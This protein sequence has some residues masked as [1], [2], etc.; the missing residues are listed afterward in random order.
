M[1]GCNQT[2]IQPNAHV[3]VTFS[4]SWDV[5]RLIVHLACHTLYAYLHVILIRPDMLHIPVYSKTSYFVFWMFTPYVAKGMSFYI[6]S[7]KKVGKNDFC[8]CWG[9]WV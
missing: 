1:L 8:V 7:E 3:V 4:V 2:F 5:C 9:G 6:V